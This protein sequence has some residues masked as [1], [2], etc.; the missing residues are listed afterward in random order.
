[1]YS[2]PWKCPSQLLQTGTYRA[3]ALAELEIGDTELTHWTGK[4]WAAGDAGAEI[5]NQF[6]TRNWPAHLCRTS[7]DL[8]W[9]T[10]SVL[11][12][13][14]VGLSSARCSWEIRRGKQRGFI[15]TLT[16][17]GRPD[18]M[19]WLSTPAKC[20]SN[21]HT[22]FGV[23]E[24]VPASFPFRFRD[25]NNSHCCWLWAIALFLVDSLNP[26]HKFVNNHDWHLFKWPRLRGP[27]VSR[28]D[29]DWS[30]GQTRG[31]VTDVEV[32]GRRGRDYMTSV[33]FLVNDNMKS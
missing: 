3:W 11:G 19:G 10:E 25:T 8:F 6:S 33:A 21:F 23:L 9:F 5:T 17:C 4:A 13:L 31:A 22:A 29:P 7:A 32:G 14:V 30:T 16:S 2:F 18:C 1:M 15:L 12:P 20:H 26:P 27:G 24:S 28:Q